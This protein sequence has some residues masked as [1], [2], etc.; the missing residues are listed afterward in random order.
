MEDKKREKKLEKQ[1]KK[2]EKKLQKQKER[3]NLNKALKSNWQLYLLALPFVVYLAIFEYKPLYGI[4]IAFKNYKP[5]LGIWGSEWVGLDN[6]RR[7]FTAN[8]FSTIVPNTIILSLYSLIAGMFPPIILSIC[9]N[10]IPSTKYK[11]FVQNITYAPHFISLVVLVSMI[12]LIFTTDSGLINNIIKAFGGEEIFFLGEGKLFRHIYVWSGVWQGVGWG[13][14]IYLASL[15]SVNPE[16]HEV[17]RVDGAT[18]MQRIRYIDWQVIK[19][20]MITLLI[21]NC[22]KIMSVGFDKA[23]LLQNTFNRPY[24]EIISTYVYKRGLLNSEYGYSTAV[25]LFNTVINIILI[26]MANKISKKVSETSLY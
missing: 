21:L 19:P 23:F 14:I 8:A 12:T 22:G 24:S 25:G 15:T 16:L 26:V 4:I 17:A 10:Y 1:N 3:K 7:F 20:T 11:K 13:S 5:F 18:I 9:L 2:A 6:F